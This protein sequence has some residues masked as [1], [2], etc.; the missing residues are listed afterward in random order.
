MNSIFASNG[1][2]GGRKWLCFHGVWNIEW[3]Y[4]VSPRQT[5]KHAVERKLRVRQI[6]YLADRGQFKIAAYLI[7]QISDVVVGLQAKTAKT[8]TQQAVKR[9]SVFFQLLLKNQSSRNQR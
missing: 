6:V 9:V 4:A 8:V 3:L 7:V 2:D 5:E 1:S